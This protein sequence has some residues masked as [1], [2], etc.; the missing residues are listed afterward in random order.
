[1]RILTVRQPWAWEII[2]GGKDVE[3][4]A[5]NIARNYRG[6]VAIHAAKVFDYSAYDE[7]ENYYDEQDPRYVARGAIIGVVDLVDVHDPGDRLF[8]PAADVQGVCSPWAEP[9]VCHLV[10]ANPRALDT[11]I[12]FT[13]GVGLRTLDVETSARL[14]EA[15]SVTVVHVAAPINPE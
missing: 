6:P 12:P 1:V 2:H 11:P 15:V 13:G 14:L 5:S 10:L 4:R 7:Q 8:L 9:D 3:N